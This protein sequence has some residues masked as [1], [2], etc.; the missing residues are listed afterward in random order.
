MISICSTGFFRKS[1][2]LLW[3]NFFFRHC[4]DVGIAQLEVMIKDLADALKLDVTKLVKQY[5]AAKPTAQRFFDSGVLDVDGPGPGAEPAH[6]IHCQHRESK[7]AA[8]EG[9]RVPRTST[10][11]PRIASACFRLVWCSK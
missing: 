4:K 5:V 11:W 3:P 9:R 6:S 1:F 7:A 8:A 2:L 10:T